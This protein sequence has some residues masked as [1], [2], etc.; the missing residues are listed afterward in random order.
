MDTPPDLTDLDVYRRLSAMADDLEQMATAAITLV[1]E[2]ALK[3]AAQNV[4]GL[5]NVIYEHCLGDDGLAH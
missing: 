1:G 5:A 3:T 4:R 2:T